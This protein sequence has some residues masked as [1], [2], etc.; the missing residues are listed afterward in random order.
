MTTGNA[1][2]PFHIDVPQAELDRLSRKLDET[3]WPEP[4]PGDGWDTG[5]PVAWLR[6]LA[7]VL[8]QRL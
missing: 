6:E 7:R 2:D 5:V 3:R 1:I 4:L 8:A